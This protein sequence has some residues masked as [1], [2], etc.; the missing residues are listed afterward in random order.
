MIPEMRIR[1][2]VPAEKIS[3]EEI[4]RFLGRKPTSCRKSYPLAKMESWNLYNDYIESYDV[5]EYLTKFIKENRLFQIR[6]K[7][8]ELSSMIGRGTDMQAGM[9]ISG[10]VYAEDEMPGIYISSE[11]LRFLD[12]AGIAFRMDIVLT[13]M[14]RRCRR[15]PGVKKT[16]EPSWAAPSPPSGARARKSHRRK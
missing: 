15:R 10:D 6:H 8:K 1:L 14:T 13:I 2:Y 12:E 7:L 16:K 9:Y 4:T 5:D 3:G 11:N